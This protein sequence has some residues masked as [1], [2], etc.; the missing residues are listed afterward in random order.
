MTPELQRSDLPTDSDRDGSPEIADALDDAYWAQLLDDAYRL[1]LECPDDE[2]VD[3]EI[4][5]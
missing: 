1:Q 5:P 4:E 2:D 3:E